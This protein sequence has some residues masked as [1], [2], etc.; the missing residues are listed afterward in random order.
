[1]RDSE[2]SEALRRLREGRSFLVTGHANPDGDALGSALALY[3]LLR[4]LGKDATVLFDLPVPANFRFL[5]LSDRIVDSA[6]TGPPFDVTFLCDCGALDRGPQGLPGRDRLGTVVVLDHH[7]TSARKGDINVVD[8][9]A[10]AVGMLVYKIGKELGIPLDPAFA[11]NIY[12]SL[13]TDTGNF[14]YQKTS[15][16]ALRLAADLVES[17]VDPWRVTSEIYESMPQ[18][19]QRLL[20][21]ALDS[22][23]YSHGGRVAI[24][25]IR[26][27]MYAVSGADSSMTDGMIN[28]AR[29]V[30]GVEVAVLFREKK[31]DGWRLSLRS[32][33]SIDVSRV[34]ARLGG[35]G[36]P[37]ASGCTMGGSLETVRQRVLEAVRMELE[38]P[39]RARGQR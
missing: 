32:R 25:T 12:C 20:A 37:N 2:W 29:G 23:E 39:Q 17:G 14:R 19:R 10:A 26:N 6:E 27:D 4:H 8:T 3:S 16:E 15:P 9:S 13:V 1:M 36:H 5:P 33:G 34:A 11:E 22:L 24:M 21:R 18:S 35:G 31:E 38:P 30:R 28:F 7:D